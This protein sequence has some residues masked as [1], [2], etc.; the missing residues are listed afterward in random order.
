[1]VKADI[2]HPP[3]PKTKDHI[4]WRHLYGA[5]PSLAITKLIEQSDQTLL[6][7]VPDNLQVARLNDEIDFFQVPARHCS[8]FLIGKRYLMI[9]F[10]RIKISSQ[11]D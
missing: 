8:T 6:I 4:R 5:S 2:F 9:I 7:I 11:K 1:M 10:L 3:F